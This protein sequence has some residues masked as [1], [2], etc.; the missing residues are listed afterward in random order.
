MGEFS[1]LRVCLELLVHWDGRDDDGNELG[2]GVYLYRLEAGQQAETRRLL[3]L[4]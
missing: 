3:L 4:R 2:T 1:R